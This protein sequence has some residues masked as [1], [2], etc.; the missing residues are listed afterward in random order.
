LVNVLHLTEATRPLTIN[1]RAAS[2]KIGLLLG[3][4]IVG[5]QL[6]ALNTSTGRPMKGWVMVEQEGIE[7]DDSLNEWIRRAEGFVVTLPG[8]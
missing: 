8:K 6:L 5:G 3:A 2:R 4:H 7:H 1:G